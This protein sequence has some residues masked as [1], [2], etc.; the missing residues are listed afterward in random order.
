MFAANFS[1][2]DIKFLITQP[3]QK[4]NLA[5]KYQSQWRPLS[6]PIKSKS[7]SKLNFL[8]QL[9]RGKAFEGFRLHT[10]PKKNFVPKTNVTRFNLIQGSLSFF[11]KTSFLLQKKNICLINKLPDNVNVDCFLLDIKKGSFYKAQWF[12][13]KILNFELLIAILNSVWI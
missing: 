13:L 7:A 9:H 2:N 11:L 8:S 10:V 12:N 5:M 6:W 3:K 4:K 1:M